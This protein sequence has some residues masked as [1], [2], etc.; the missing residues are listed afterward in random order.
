MSTLKQPVLPQAGTVQCEIRE[1]F[2]RIIILA[3][4]GEVCGGSSLKA[5][6]VIRSRAGLCLSPGTKRSNERTF[7]QLLAFPRTTLREGLFG[8]P[9]GAG[10]G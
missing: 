2:G 7:F 9:P 6:K 4:A 3:R 1:T 8:A 10:G 5:V